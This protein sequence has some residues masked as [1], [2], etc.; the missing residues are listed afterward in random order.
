[1]EDLK[2]KKEPRILRWILMTFM[3]LSIA[4]SIVAMATLPFRLQQLKI[5]EDEEHERVED[6]IK[7]NDLV[8]ILVHVYNSID[9]TLNIIFIIPVGLLRYKFITTYAVLMILNG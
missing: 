9:I 4:L 8:A 1:M 7:E 3:I 6:E 2:S 5:R